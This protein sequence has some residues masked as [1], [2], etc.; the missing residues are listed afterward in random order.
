VVFGG[1]K[2]GDWEEGMKNP[3]D[4]YKYFKI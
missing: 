2:I 1:R 3:E 4:G